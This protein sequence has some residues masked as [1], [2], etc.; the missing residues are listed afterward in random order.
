M[1]EMNTNLSELIGCIIGDGNI[2]DRSIS[3]VEIA[4][5]ANKDKH[6]F[7][8]NLSEIVKSEIKCDP[9]VFFHSGALRLRINNKKFVQFLTNLGIPTGDGKSKSVLIPQSIAD[10]SNEIKKHCIRGIFDTDGS[11]YYDKRSVYNK[12]YIRIELHMFNAGLLKQVKEILHSFGLSAVYSSKR[13]ALYFNGYENVRKYIN[14]VGFSN[15]RHIERIKMMYPELL[16]YNLP[17]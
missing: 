1:L 6:Y 11:V 13:D 15:H 10:G 5:D 2:Y 14:E 4:G 9:K 3:Y 16:Q 17:Q 8:N 7:K 12:P